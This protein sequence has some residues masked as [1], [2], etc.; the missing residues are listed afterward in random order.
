MAAEENTRT[1]ARR[2]LTAVADISEGERLTQDM[3]TA[4]RPAAGI[5]P[6]SWKDVVGRRARRAI[7]A[8]GQ[9]T[10]GDLE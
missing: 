6:A 8:G 10:W 9:L 1:V 2:S 7:L 3:V 4:L 5:S